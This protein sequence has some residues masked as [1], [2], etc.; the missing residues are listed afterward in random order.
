MS[1]YEAPS[2]RRALSLGLILGLG[3]LCK[4]VLLAWAALLACGVAWR[5]S[6]HTPAGAGARQPSKWEAGETPTAA[7]RPGGRHALAVVAALSLTIAPWTAR[8][9]AI[10]GYLV[11]ISSNA[12]MNLLIGHEPE[13]RGAYRDGAD[14]VGLLH[15]IVG[16]QPDA[17]SRERAVVRI[18]LSWMAEAPLRTIQLGMRKLALFWSP[19]VEGETLLRNL[20]AALSYL[21][22]L[23]LALWGL[24]QLRR[25]P[26]AWP[27]TALALALSLVHA[28]FFAHTRFRLPLDAALIV[29]AAWSVDHLL[30]RRARS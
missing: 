3:A 4:P 23:G 14:Y 12:G 22:V 2:A 11:P 20:V 24:W 5:R 26:I 29:P 15:H 27:L 7:A 21:P 13:A 6:G 30:S 25:H 19:I 8:N 10:T 17:I 1:Y 16:P 18:V 9:Y 28:L